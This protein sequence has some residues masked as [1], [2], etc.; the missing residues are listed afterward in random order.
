MQR[1]VRTVFLLYTGKS[2]SGRAF[3]ILLVA[4]DADMILAVT[5]TFGIISRAFRAIMNVKPE[6]HANYRVKYD[7]EYFSSKVEHVKARPGEVPWD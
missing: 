1:I 7:H 5:T 2:L 4:N 3:E 6:I